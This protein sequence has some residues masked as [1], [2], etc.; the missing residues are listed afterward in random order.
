MA[1]NLWPD[2]SGQRWPNAPQRLVIFALLSV[3]QPWWRQRTSS[4]VGHGPC[5]SVPPRLLALKNGPDAPKLPWPASGQTP[6]A[7]GQRCAAPPTLTG[8]WRQRP[9]SVSQR[10]TLLR[11][12]LFL[13]LCSNVLT[14]KCITLCTCVSIFSQIFSRVML[15]HTSS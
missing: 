11:L 15:A 5:A 6:R 13:N 12:Y 14:T 4:I 2:A 7:L 3:R 9:V 1:Q 8:H 10:E